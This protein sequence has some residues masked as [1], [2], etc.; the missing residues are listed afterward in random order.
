LFAEARNLGWPEALEKILDI[1]FSQIC[2]C[3]SKN[4]QREDW[5]A[6]PRVAQILKKM[7]AAASLSVDN[8]ELCCGDFKVVEQTLVADNLFDDNSMSTPPQ[9]GQ[10]S[11]INIV[12]PDMQW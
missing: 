8:L 10:Q 3:Q 1:M 9:R 6:V 4:Q 12:T 11:S 7:D 5:D 2:A